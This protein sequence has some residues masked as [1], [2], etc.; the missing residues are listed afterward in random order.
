MANKRV[1]SSTPPSFH[2]VIA[3]NKKKLSVWYQE[4]LS[5]S[6]TGCGKCCTG[7]PGA[8]W[9]TE[10]EMIAIGEFLGIS[11]E[12][13]KDK[14]T[15]MLGNR[16]A[17]KEQPPKNGDF[18]CIFLEENKCRIYAARPKQ[19][20]TYPWWKEN[21]TSKEAW[22]EQAQMCEGINHP[23]APLFSLEEIESQLH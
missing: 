4:G 16:R 21:L 20:K 5:F 22:E 6:C 23:D 9:V 2:L 12:E 11:M 8:V 13:V 14:Y 17:L 15:R 19:C 1:G 18:D 3:M 10:E 7:S